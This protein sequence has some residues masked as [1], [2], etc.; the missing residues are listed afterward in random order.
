MNNT[1]PIIAILLLGFLFLGQK[2][3]YIRMAP[4]GDSQSEKPSAA[5]RPGVASSLLPKVS[6]DATKFDPKKLLQGQSF[7]HGVPG[8]V[9]GSLRNAN[10]QIR[11]DPM[12]PRKPVS[13]FNQSTIA[14]DTM[15]RQMNIGGVVR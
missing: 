2:S 9:V 10:Q 6:H 5:S 15:Q 1:L 12:I 8:S 11:S 3:N 13:I 7:I 4:L 14:T